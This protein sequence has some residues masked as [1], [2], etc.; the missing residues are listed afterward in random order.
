MS[1]LVPLSPPAPPGPGPAAPGAAGMLVADPEVVST[2]RA[3]RAADGSDRWDEV[4]NGVYIL[5]PLPNFE[6]Q[7]L[8]TRISAALMPFVDDPGAGTTAA[9]CNVSDVADP[10]ADWRTNYRCPDVVVYLNDNPAEL[11]GSHWFGGPD[12]AVEI[13]SPGDRSRQKLA[14]YAGVGVRELFVLDREP[15]RLELY[16]LDGGELNSVGSTGP[17]GD[18]LTTETVPLRWTLTAADPPA[19]AV[20]A[21]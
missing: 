1:A 8:A 5:M 20:A 11:R 15:W 18:P 2:L 17:G 14:F 12:L 7:V 19:V 13:V 3:E 9:G 6:H 10:A 4:W 21:A 16:R